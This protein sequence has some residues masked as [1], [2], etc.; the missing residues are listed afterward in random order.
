MS[1]VDALAKHTNGAVIVAI[2]TSV[3]L[4]QLQN[5]WPTTTRCVTIDGALCARRQQLF[6]TF[7]TLLGFP[8]Y[9]GNNWD[10]FSEVM[11]DRAFTP[12][13]DRIIC[14]RDMDRVL[15]LESASQRAIL[16]R[17]LNR[18][19]GGLE[20]SGLQ[21]VENWPYPNVWLVLDLRSNRGDWVGILKQYG[22]RLVWV[23]ECGSW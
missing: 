8:K 12:S 6:D 20:E 9:F 1:V 17:V 23:P 5:T 15:E 21:N 10:A 2:V 11:R 4:T 22:P 13:G 18:V 14:V 3:E 7:R 19:A 16:A